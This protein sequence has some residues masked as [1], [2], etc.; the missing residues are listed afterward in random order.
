MTFPKNLAIGEMTHSATRL[1]S[2]RAAKLQYNKLPTCNFQS[3]QAA[4]L[5]SLP[6]FKA[7]KVLITSQFTELPSCRVVV[8]HPCHNIIFK[9]P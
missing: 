3:C 8:S 9:T 7:T 6:E 5:P 1:P 2:C 4:E